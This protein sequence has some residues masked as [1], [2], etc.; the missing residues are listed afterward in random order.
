MTAFFRIFD[1]IFDLARGKQLHRHNTFCDKLDFFFDLVRSEAMP[2]I[3]ITGNSYCNSARY[4]EYLCDQSPALEASQSA[5]RAY[6]LAA[7]ATLTGIACILSLYVH[8]RISIF[9]V[10]ILYIFSY[11]IINFFI[12]M[13]A[14]TGDG[15]LIVYLQNE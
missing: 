7:E 5:S 9:S 2:Y 11:F 12:Q 14:D 13:H 15:I 1:T 6:R 4:C 10:G 8:G 3:S